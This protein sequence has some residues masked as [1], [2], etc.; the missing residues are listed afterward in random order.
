MQTCSQ[1]TDEWVQSKK[2]CTKVVF[3]SLLVEKLGSFQHMYSQHHLFSIGYHLKIRITDTNLES[4]L[5]SAL[6]LF[7]QFHQSLEGRNQVFILPSC[8]QLVVVVPQVYSSIFYR[9]WLPD[10]CSN[11][12][13]SQEAGGGVVRK[14]LDP[15]TGWERE[16]KSRVELS[17]KWSEKVAL[18][19]KKDMVFSFMKN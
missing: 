15:V 7:E 13:C 5:P 11:L 10:L 16:K 6:C 2:N 17:G 9:P 3:H 14:S 19:W 4:G 8:Q 12:C 1:N 18:V